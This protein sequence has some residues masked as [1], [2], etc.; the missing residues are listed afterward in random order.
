WG[1]GTSLY[2][3]DSGVIRKVDTQTGVVSLFADVWNG[4]RVPS[5]IFSPPRPYV[6]TGNT[7]SL[8]AFYSQPLFGS[9]FT[10]LGA[11]SIREISFSSGE[12]RTIPSSA[13]AGV[14]PTAM[15]ADD[16]FLYLAY[17]SRPGEISLARLNLS[18]EMFE[19]LFGFP[20]A[21]GADPTQPSVLDL[22]VP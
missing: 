3:T 15:W 20:L 7:A 2:V 6:L 18:T 14:M 16:Q 12:A 8:F 9:S 5:G 19:P 10:P 11:P 17:A 21:P 1:N 13:Y 4:D 22:F